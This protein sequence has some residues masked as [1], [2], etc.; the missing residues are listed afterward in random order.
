MG[1]KPPMAVVPAYFHPVTDP[2][3]W[4]RI[5]RGASMVRLVVINMA[6]G[7]GERPDPRYRDVLDL[8]AQSSVDVA[9]YVDTDYARRDTDTALAEAAKYLDW[10]GVDAVFLDQV[11]TGTD[12]VDYYAKLSGRARGCG[13]RLLAFNHGTY[14]AAQYADHAELL[15][16]FEGPWRTYAQTR[17][18]SGIEPWR[19]ERLFHLIY[20]VPAARHA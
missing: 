15:G 1:A 7:P 10:Y 6:N 8:L 4:S 17:A 16:T 20:S 14:P 12:Q 11:S 5:V 2:T 19:P 3:A 9:G 13:V 18:P